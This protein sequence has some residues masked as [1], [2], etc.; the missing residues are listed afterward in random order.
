MHVECC[1]MRMRVLEC[2]PHVDRVRAF[3]FRAKKK[4]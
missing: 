4:P 3:S 1:A 2:A